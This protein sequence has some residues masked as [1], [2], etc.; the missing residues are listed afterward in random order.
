MNSTRHKK[1]ETPKSTEQSETSKVIKKKKVE[2]GVK[3]S[4]T[5]QR[6]LTELQPSPENP[7]A[8]I[9]T[10]QPKKNDLVEWNYV[11]PSKSRSS[12][13]VVGRRTNQP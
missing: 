11:T 7:S 8:F 10:L 12:V 6:M 1:R 9:A 4:P 5:R 2:K 3:M 13:K